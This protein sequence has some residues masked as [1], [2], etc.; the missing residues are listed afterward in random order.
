MYLE[1]SAYSRCVADRKST[2]VFCVNV[3][4]VIALTAA[5]RDAGIDARYLHA[6]TP[7]V[8]RKALVEAFRAG[9]YPVLINCGTFFLGAVENYY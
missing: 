2:L 4:H 3:A 1:W 5:F 9:K 7:A 8:E 6:S